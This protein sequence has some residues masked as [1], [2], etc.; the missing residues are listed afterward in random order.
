VTSV[1]GCEHELLV[2]RCFFVIVDF[3]GRLIVPYWFFSLGFKEFLLR[4]QISMLTVSL[5]FIF[6]YLFG[7]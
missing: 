7:L 5:L 6:G 1:K 3:L 2:I 4:N